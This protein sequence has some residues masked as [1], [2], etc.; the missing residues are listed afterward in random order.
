MRR[1]TAVV[2]LLVVLAGC[3]AGS[4]SGTS[5]AGSKSAATVDRGAGAAI[6]GPAAQPAAQPVG[7]P[8]GGAATLS[9]PR[10]L[11][12]TA[13]LEVQVDDVKKAAA[14]AQ[15]AVLDAGGQLVDEQL[16]LQ[17]H[18]PQASLHAQV[19]PARLPAVLDRLAGLGRE[20]SRRLGTDDVTD[21]VVDLDSRLATQR[22]SVARVR[23]LL[24]RASSL[25]DVVRLEGELSRRE[26]DLESLQ[27]RERALAGQVALADVR[28]DLT[29]ADGVAAPAGTTGFRDGLRGGW[30]AFTASTRLLASTLGAVL[31]FLPLLAGAAWF[32]LRL[33]RRATAT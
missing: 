12:R 22:G 3:T 23:A 31:P 8:A 1:L 2:P 21:A 25:G 9:L 14:A 4:S 7:Q 30:R 24:D 10:S 20:R 17:A 26:A 11:V 28:V 19:P 18:S 27:A 32:A 29:T 15:Q 6:G 16:D 33:R 13:Q 5:S